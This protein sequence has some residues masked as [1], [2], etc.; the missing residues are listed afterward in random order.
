MAKERIA[1]SDTLAAEVM[2]A[3]DRTCCVCRTEKQKV[4][5]H[6]IDEDPANNS[7]DNLAVICLH[8]HSDAHSTGAFV[9]N[10]TPS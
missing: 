4:Q 1:I 10:V 7:F 3:S 5:I 9:R 6:H 8:C 2:F